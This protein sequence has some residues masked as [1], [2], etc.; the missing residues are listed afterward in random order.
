[1]TTLY[2]E[3]SMYAWLKKTSYLSNPFSIIVGVNPSDLRF[4]G[5]EW[6]LY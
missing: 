5:R 2:Y 4:G 3:K 6:N 1:M